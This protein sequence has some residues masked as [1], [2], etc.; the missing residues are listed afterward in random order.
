MS[1]YSIGKLTKRVIQDSRA[2]TVSGPNGEQYREAFERAINMFES[3][4]EQIYTTNANSTVE[5]P[6]QDSFDERTGQS[7][8]ALTL[9]PSN[10][11]LTAAIAGY[12]RKSMTNL[13]VYFLA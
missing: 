5:L 13:E 10:I 11:I 12:K 6:D 3:N 1:C 4:P 2:K 7:E 8:E 9:M